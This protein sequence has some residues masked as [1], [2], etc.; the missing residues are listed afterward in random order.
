MSVRKR[1]EIQEVL[2]RVR[3]EEME[4][5]RSE[6]RERRKA[7]ASWVL[8]SFSG[9]LLFAAFPPVGAS[10]LAFVALIPFVVALRWNPG[11]RCRLGFLAGLFFW[12]PSLWFLSP[13]TIPGAVFLAAYCAAYW[14]LLGGVWGWA[15][16]QWTPHRIL[17][18]L[19][20]VIGCAAFWCLLEWIRSWFLTGFPWNELAVSQWENY[21]LL[22]VASVGGT[23]L[24]SFVIVLMN[25]GISFS[26]L[27]LV[28][29]LGTGKRNRMHPELYLPILV[30]CIGFTWGMKE[31]HRL[32]PEG[33]E[34]RSFR[35][36]AIQ[37]LAENKWTE[38][39]AAENFRVLWELSDAAVSLKPD[40][41]VWPETALPEELRYSTKAVSMVQ[42][43]VANGTPLLLGSLDF[44]TTSN[45]KNQVERIYYNSSFLV[46][47][48]G[49]IAEEYRKQH[50]VM[51]GEYMPFAKFFP[52][53]R[54][55][56]PMPEDVTPGEGSGVIQVKG[57]DLKLGMIIC[58]EDLMPGLSR[59]R[60]DEG[61][62][63]LMNQTNDAWFDPLWGSEA[64]LAHAVF[65]SVE[66]R[67]PTVRVTN[68]GVSAWIDTRGV[69]RDRIEDP[70]TDEI[71][72]RGFKTFEVEVP[73]DLE[74]TFYHRYAYLFPVVWAFLSALILF[75]KMERRLPAG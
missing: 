34:Q 60:A 10:H 57:L 52:F 66:Q 73:A 56:T 35:I 17:E 39:L 31:M 75:A 18:S 71:R 25:L 32:F 45:E 67:R 9:I 13:V 20:L 1:K 61:A 49:D 70:L 62:Q 27:G 16:K 64:H 43:L 69:V 4:E 51:F 15:I 58:F 29:Q 36:A 24:I 72:I 30:L 41:L 65:R 74:T 8:S 37:P 6:M 33:Q 55:L 50:L 40:L 5:S 26:L 47:S 63:L 44:E 54:A 3:V 23:R 42:N 59:D 68:S 48:S 12:I 14:I 22:Q 11:A 2:R 19:A 53:L 28:E 7:L 38:E 46:D 21:G